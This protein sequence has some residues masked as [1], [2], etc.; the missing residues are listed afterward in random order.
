MI[1]DLEIFQSA[2]LIIDKYADDAEAEAERRG[3]AL[4]AEGATEG[5]RTW[6]RI[7]GAIGQLRQESPPGALH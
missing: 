5:H 3:L 1:S 6:M 2:K 7:K 4:L